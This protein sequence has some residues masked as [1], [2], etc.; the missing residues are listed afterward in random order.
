MLNPLRQYDSLVH[1][2]W[3]R[4]VSGRVMDVS[5]APIDNSF[6]PVIHTLGVIAAEGL[7]PH[8]PPQ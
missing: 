6:P 3:K 1:W 5:R 2:V 7:S 8:I 4:T